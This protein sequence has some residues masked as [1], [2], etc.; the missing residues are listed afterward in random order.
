MTSA[1]PW[2]QADIRARRRRR[3]SAA[4]QSGGSTSHTV[5]DRGPRRR[6][7]VRRDRVFMAADVREIAPPDRGRARRAWPALDPGQ[8]AAIAA[9]RQ[10]VCD[11]TAL[12]L[13]RS[14]PKRTALDG[15]L[16]CSST[17]SPITNV[18]MRSCRTVSKNNERPLREAECLSGEISRPSSGPGRASTATP[19]RS[20]IAGMTASR[21]RLAGDPSGPDRGDEPAPG[22]SS[23]S[24]TVRDQR[25]DRP[26]EGLGWDPP[27]ARP[28]PSRVTRPVKATRFSAARRVERPD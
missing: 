18:E 19:V 23:A 4:D 1:A 7:V 24:W 11:D 12:I 16:N 6:R 2:L 13:G 17:R 21:P 15:Q 3:P 22:P 14:R 26:F 20:R 8:V 5:Q 10:S 9:A 28:S 27:A 25:D